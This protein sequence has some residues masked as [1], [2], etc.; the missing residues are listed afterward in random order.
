MSYASEI[1]ARSRWQRF[2]PLLP[3]SR[4]RTTLIAWLFVQEKIL[5]IKSSEVP[6]LEARPETPE[7]WET[8]KRRIQSWQLPFAWVS[9]RVREHSLRQPR[10]LNKLHSHSHPARRRPRRTILTSPLSRSYSSWPFRWVCRSSTCSSRRRRTR[11]SLRTNKRRNDLTSLNNTSI[12]KNSKCQLWTF[13]S[14]PRSEMAHIPP[15]IRSE[16]CT[17]TASMR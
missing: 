8:S 2:R 9:K 1:P 3:L 4:T 15:F 16:G 12:N 5:V 10:P 17:I 11:R 14:S 7:E 13:K 6:S